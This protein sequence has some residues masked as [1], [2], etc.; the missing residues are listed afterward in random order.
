MRRR[1]KQ[2]ALGNFTTAG[3]RVPKAVR[4]WL[5]QLLECRHGL[6]E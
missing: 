3:K 6:P 5:Q 2:A 1:V 4:R